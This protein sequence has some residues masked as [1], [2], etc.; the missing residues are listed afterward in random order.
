MLSFRMNQGKPGSW[1]S[2]VYAESQ[3][4]FSV[5]PR[6]IEAYTLICLITFSGGNPDADWAHNLGSSALH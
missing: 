3:Y 6:R 2:T 1:A 4:A 5:S